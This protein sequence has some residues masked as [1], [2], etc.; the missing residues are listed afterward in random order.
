MS[1]L[2]EKYIKEQY[3]D[4]GILTSYELIIPEDFNYAYDVMDELAKKKP[5][6]RA[7][8]WVSSTGVRKEITYKEMMEKSNQC[9]NYLVDLGIKKGDMV[10]LILKRHYQWWYFM[11]ALHKIGAIAIPATNQL[12]VKD[13]VYRFDA[14]NVKAV[15]CTGEGI[16][17]DSVDEAQ[18][19]CPSVEIKIMCEGEK[20][21]WRNYSEISSYSKEFKRPQGEDKITNDD[22][23]LLY[24]T[25]GTTGFP[26]M[27]IHDFTYPIGHIYTARHWHNVK[28]DGLH[29]SVAETGWAKAAWGKI[30]GQWFCE[31]ALLVYD[32]ERFDADNL[33]EVISSEKVTTFCAPPTIYRFMI[34]HDLGKYDLSSIRHATIAGEALNAEVFEKFKEYTGLKLMEGFGQTETTVAVCNNKYMNPKPGSMG[35]PVMQYKISVCDSDDLPVEPGEVGE[36]C[37]DIRDGRPCGLFLGYYKNEEATDKVFKNGIYHTGDLVWVD[38][39]GYFWYVGRDDDIIKSS[40]YRIGPF[41]IESA[42]MEHDAVM[43][44]AVT[45]APDPIRGQ[46]VK[47]TIVLTKKYSPSEELKKDIQNYVKKAT[48]PYKYPRIVEFVDE[49]PKTIS[50]KIKRKEIRDNDHA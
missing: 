7:M 10:M 50:G 31:T 1:L 20:D 4:A 38:E 40:G 3:N 30:Y 15:I 26:K 34:Q 46:V 19:K 21:G 22:I 5:G 41:E 27:V 35:K 18:K 17:A 44:C 45:A 48:A 29:I 11:L 2:C 49:L 28:E 47:A 37:F 8:L 14:A 12:M 39:D 25:S 32:M 6:N 13:L 43:E 42:L 33:L 36:I 23:M 16:I 9:A 24:F